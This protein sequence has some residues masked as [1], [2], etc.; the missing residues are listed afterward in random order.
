MKEENKQIYYQN[1]GIEELTNEANRII[2]YLEKCENIEA[3][4]DTY[5]NL[6]KLN[7]LIEKKFHSNSK[8]INLKTKE[9]IIEISEKKNAK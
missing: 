3:E 5:Q 9:K 8:N 6:I 2:D 7:N 4:N 1:M